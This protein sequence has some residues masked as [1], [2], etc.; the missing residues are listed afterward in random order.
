[1]T[2]SPV[3]LLTVDAMNLVRRVYQA[4][5]APDSDEKALGAVRSC[6]YSLMRALRTH[7]PTH[8]AFVLEGTGPTWRHELYPQYKLGRTPAPEPLVD[9]IPLLLDALK[10]LGWATLQQPDYEADDIISSL[11]YEAG[12]L[13]LESEHPVEHVILTTDKDIVWCHTL[14]AKVFDHF[15]E[16][17][18]DAD[19]LMAR[20]GIRPEQ[21][22]DYLALVG[23]PV[24]G[25]PGVDKVGAKTAAKLLA[26]YN[27]LEGVLAAA[28]CIGGKLGERLQAQADLARLSRKLTDL[29]LDLFQGPVKLNWAGLKA[30]RY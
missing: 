28:P 8:A 19:W 26:T 21:M 1:M 29:R 11:A 25:I 4:N 23:D 9:A 3:K 30:P 6:T 18:R 14:G 12:A 20:K 24:D 27:D 2:D 16:I 17:W 7:Q 22:L 13:A 10:A 5:P 15:S